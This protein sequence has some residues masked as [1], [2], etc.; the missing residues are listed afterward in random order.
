MP[1]AASK[2]DVDQKWVDVKRK[3]N[4]VALAVD[5]EETSTATCD[6]SIYS[7]PDT[8]FSSNEEE[9]CYA[10]EV[11]QDH[12]ASASPD[13]E[14][15]D[16]LPRELERKA[17]S[18]LKASQY[19]GALDLYQLAILLL[20]KKSDCRAAGPARAPQSRE[21]SLLLAACYTNASSC[22]SELNGWQQ[23]YDLAEQVTVILDGIEHDEDDEGFVPILGDVDK[24]RVG[25]MRAKC[26][27]LMARSLIRQRRTREASELFRKARRVI[28][29]YSSVNNLVKEDGTIMTKREAQKQKQEETKENAQEDANPREEGDGGGVIYGV[30]DLYHE[31]SASVAQRI[32]RSPAMGAV[33][34]SVRRVPDDG[35]VDVGRSVL[36]GGASL[37]SRWWGGGVGTVVGDIAY[38]TNWDGR[39]NPN[40]ASSTE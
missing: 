14:S 11:R 36:E 4:S 28:R 40:T 29:R 21:P 35:L 3:W 10:A 17:S 22:Y 39:S 33:Q 26:F 20:E 23:A 25:D 9:D 15:G 5:A 7:T 27:L 19:S 13:L 18:L 38:A 16:P 31:V 24:K 6:D 32:A 12:E 30:L 8:S 37:L 2:I 34:E 1:T